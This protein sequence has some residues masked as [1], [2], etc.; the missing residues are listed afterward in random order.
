M[1]TKF[2]P[3]EVET[4]DTTLRDGAQTRGVTFT[5]QDKLRIAS[6]LDAFGIHII[7]GGWPG[8]NPKDIEFFKRVKDYDLKNSKIA[9]FGSTRRKNVSV[10]EDTNLSMILEADTECAVLVG[11]AWD[12]HVTEVLKCTL[13][14]NLDMVYDSIKFLEEH[15]V[16]CYLD[17][18]HYYD[19]FKRNPAYALECIKTAEEAKADTIVLCDTNGGC[20]S[21]E[22]FEITKRAAEEVKSRLGIHV[23]NDSGCAVANTIV[24]VQAGAEHVQGTINGIG[25]R[26]GNADLCQVLPNLELK[27]GIRALR[28]DRPEGRRLENLVEISRYVYE[29][30]GM[31]PNSFQPYTGKYAF[32][33]KAGLHVDGVMKVSEAYEHLDPGLVN[34]VRIITVSELSGRANIVAL[35]RKFGLE[36]SK[37]D[38]AIQ[39]ILEEIKDLELKGY[40][41]DNADATIYLI[42]ARHLALSKKRFDLLSWSVVSEDKDGVRSR[43]EVELMVNGERVA[44]GAI[45]DGPVHA[46]DLALKKALERKYPRI[47]RVKLINYKVSIVGVPRDTAS[48][49]RV[50]IEFS[51][52]RDTWA[53]TSA[54]RNILEASIEALV[55]GYEYYLQKAFKT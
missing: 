23:H 48:N 11:K 34:N 15:G 37:E 40:S 9:V 25:E 4:L 31:M 12:L 47:D 44:E 30:S 21:Q 32:A 43:G 20:L 3:R 42:L 19:G 10:H 27:L 54:S 16:R 38:P 6:R 46:Q 8:S 41:L 26:T 1:S 51:D 45:G 55:D 52:D 22:V 2:I 17:A 33:H 53:T 13:Q 50:F 18:E 14:E 7:E 24:A 5:L 39:G 35:A 36:L 49:V 28:T 29:L